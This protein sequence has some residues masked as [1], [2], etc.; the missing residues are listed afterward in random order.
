MAGS[1]FLAISGSTILNMW[2]DRDIDALMQRTCWRPLPTG[3]IGPN[4][5]LALGFLLALAGTVGALAL[6]PLFGTILFAGVFFDVL[7]YTMWLKRRTPW[8]IIWG[9]IAGAMPLLAGRALAVGHVDW[10]GLTLAAA[11]LFWI[12]THVLTFG[13]HYLVDY[14]RAGIPTVPALYGFRRTRAIIALSSILAVAAMALAAAGIG[15]TAGYWAVLLVISGALFVLVTMSMIRPSPR[16][17]FSL[18]K[19]A[20]LYMLSAMLIIVT[21]TL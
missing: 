3:Q 13:M 8:S 1:L 19:R 6:N 16:L 2:Y 20:S 18:F 21:G 11:I 17:D 15:L 4:E 5:A 12:P 9:G 10:I 14:E 7:T